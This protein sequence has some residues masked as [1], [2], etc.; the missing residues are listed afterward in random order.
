MEPLLSFN[1]LIKFTIESLPGLRIE[2]TVS[3]LSG[4]FPDPDPDP[5]YDLVLESLILKK[6]TVY[7]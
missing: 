6:Y 1:L 2:I 3:R 7:K 5:G 4:I